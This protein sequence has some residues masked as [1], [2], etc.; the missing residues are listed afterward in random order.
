METVTINVQRQQRKNYR[1]IPAKIVA[2]GSPPLIFQ[3]MGG[4]LSAEISKETPVIAA[5]FQRN[6]GNHRFFV[7]KTGGFAFVF[8]PILHYRRK[9]SAK[10]ST[11]EAHK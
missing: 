4:N 3:D 2:I 11:H 7:R 6:A 5:M 1:Q 8:P 9:I 10:I